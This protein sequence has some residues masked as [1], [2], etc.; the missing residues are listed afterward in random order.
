[1]MRNMSFPT[2]NRIG[3]LGALSNMSDQVLY[4]WLFSGM[5]QHTWKAF[6]T[7]GAH[8]AR[9]KFTNK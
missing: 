4:V 1:M 5:G 8:M 2:N 7:Q 9:V 3:K 6:A